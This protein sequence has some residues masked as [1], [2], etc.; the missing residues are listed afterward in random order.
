[1]RRVVRSVYKGFKWVDVAARLLH[2]LP[3]L[4][5]EGNPA[6]K[7]LDPEAGPGLVTGGMAH[8]LTPAGA[9]TRCPQPNCS[10]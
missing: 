9:G 3:Q 6:A 8:M 2:P 1:M 7:G 5:H 4:D 10:R